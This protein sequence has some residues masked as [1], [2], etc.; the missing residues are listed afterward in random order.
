MALREAMEKYRTTAIAVAAGM[1]LITL[2]SVWHSL[3]PP[4]KMSTQS[5]FSTDDGK[6]FFADS[7][8]RIPPF[9]HDG[10]PAY[11]CYVFT[12]DGG[13]TKYVGWLFRYTD[14]GKR[15]L[16]QSR[17]HPGGVVGSS[18]YECIE[19]KAPGTG[20]HGWLPCNNP[21]AARIQRVAKTGESE[22]VQV[23]AE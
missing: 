1:I 18:I 10:K 9:D 6:T 15:R 3:A 20:D 16:E 17:T 11:G 7:S 8:S 5:F 14:E 23:A 12:N 4:K 13:K 21:E 19:V 22:P 2:L